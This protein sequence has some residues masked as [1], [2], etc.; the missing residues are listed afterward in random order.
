MKHTDRLTH[1]AFLTGIIFKG[2]DGCLELVGGAALLLTNQAAIIRMV[3]WLTREELAE[4]PHDFVATHAM[5]WAQHFS[6][7]TQHFAALYLLAHGAIKIA[8]VAG[9]L[10]GLRWSY[11]VALIVL[12]VFIAY[13]GYRLSHRPTWPLGFLTALDL[14][15]MILI[16][17]EWRSTAGAGL[18]SWK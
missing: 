11:P 8:L 6:A 16:W 10:R 9:L 17:R 2:I 18:H 7:G 15:V 14:V 4:N 1:R 13:Q 3:A 5:Q 12:T